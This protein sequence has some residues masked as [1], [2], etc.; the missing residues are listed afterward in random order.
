MAKNAKS[1][2][3]GFVQG[4]ELARVMIV[5]GGATDGG[6]RPL[7]VAE[8]R[9]FARENANSR[10][11]VA[12]A[13]GLRVMLIDGQKRTIAGKDKDGKKAE[14]EPFVDPTLLR[15]YARPRPY[16]KKAPSQQIHLY[17]QTKVIASTLREQEAASDLLVVPV[18]PWPAH[19]TKYAA[20]PPF[21]LVEGHYGVEINLTDGNNKPN[22]LGKFLGFD[23]TTLFGGFGIT[24]S[25]N[26]P[27]ALKA[28]L[29]A[30][31]I[32]FEGSLLD[33]TR[34]EG[35]AE[36][37]DGVFRLE[38]GVTPSGKPSYFL[39]LVRAVTPDQQAAIDALEAR[40]AAAFASLGSAG[41]PVAV[42]Y[43]KRPQV[44]PLIWALDSATDVLKLVKSSGAD[45]EMQ[46]DRGAVDVRIAT[47]GQLGDEEQGLA[48][49]FANRVAWRRQGAAVVEIQVLAGAEASE[50]SLQ[51]SFA[52][53]DDK[54]TLW[55]GQV[56]SFNPNDHLQAPLWPVAER[57][58]PLYRAA[59]AM[60]DKIDHAPYFFIPVEEGCVQIALPAPPY[61]DTPAIVA[62]AAKQPPPSSAMS[63]RIYALGG[64]SVRGLVLDD[65]AGI[66]LTIAWKEALPETVVLKALGPRGQLVGFLFA[67]ESS[68][69]AR[70]ALPNLKGGPA[71]TRDLPLWFGATP[72][73]PYLTTA[74]KWQPAGGKFEATV[75]PNVTPPAEDADPIALAWL[76]SGVSPFVTNHPLT[77]SL[78]AV[79]E[80]SMSRG[81]LPRQLS[82]AFKLSFADDKGHL[83]SFAGGGQTWW[84][85]FDYSPQFRNDTLVL[86]TLA[87][88]EF[89]PEA[90][91]LETFSL[92][93][94]LRFDLPILDELFAWTDPPKKA[95]AAPAT[96]KFEAISLPTAL[97]PIRLKQVWD[98][99]HRRMALTHTQSAH[100]TPWLTEGVTAKKV[101]ISGLVETYSWTTDV[102]VQAAGAPPYGSFKLGTLKF[103]LNGAAEGLGGDKP[104]ALG[105]SGD[106]L[107]E[108]GT[109]VLEVAGFAANLYDLAKMRW[110][111]RGFGVA[112]AAVDGARAAKVRKWETSTKIVETALSL[113]TMPAAASIEGLAD[114][115]AWGFEAPIRFFAR[116]LPLVQA[117]FN[118]MKNPVEKAVGAQGQAFDQADFAESLHEWRLFEGVTSGP[119]ES[120]RRYDIRWGPF[121]FRPLRLLRAEFDKS[122]VKLIQ[123]AGSM[124]LDRPLGDTG[125]PFGPDDI[126]EHGD[127]VQLKLTRKVDAWTYNWAG[128]KMTRTNNSVEFEVD[129]PPEITFEVALTEKGATYRFEKPVMA[130]VT[131]DISKTDSARL[132][133]R[134][135]GSDVVLQTKINAT[136][137]GFTA[138]L[139]AG[140]SKDPADSHVGFSPKLVFDVNGTKSTL[141]ISGPI[142]IWPNSGKSVR[143][144][145]EF[146]PGS[147]DW[148]D[149]TSTASWAIRV[150]HASGLLYGRKEFF[151]PGAVLPV[152]SL[153]AKAG[154]RVTAAIAAVCGRI[155]GPDLGVIQM[156]T[157][158]MRITATEN[159]SPDNRVN[160]RLTVSPAI[161]DHTLELSWSRSFES[162]IRWPIDQMQDEQGHPLDAAWLDPAK[163]NHQPT[164]RSRIVRMA[165]DDNARLRHHVTVHLN[166]HTVSADNLAKDNVTTVSDTV[167]LLA[168]ADHELRHADGSRRAHWTTLDHLA[169]TTPQLM[170]RE[171]DTYTFA[172]RSRDHKYRSQVSPDGQA[173]IIRLTLA[174]AGFHDKL[175]TATLWSKSDR[176]ILL[177]GSAALFPARREENQPRRDY[178]AIV[179]W[180]MMDGVSPIN[181]AAG[182]WRI[183]APDLWPA[184]P[185]EVGGAISGVIVGRKFSSAAILEQFG[186]GR[187]VRSSQDAREAEAIIPVEQAYFE[188]WLPKA[189]NKPAMP[190]KMQPADYHGA[191]FFLRAMMAIESRIKE[192]QLASEKLGGWPKEGFDWRAE[193]LQAARLTKANGFAPA[194]A[195]LRV[196]IGIAERSLPVGPYPSALDES[197]RLLSVTALSPGKMTRRSNYRRVASDV[198]EI[199]RREAIETARDLDQ[200]ALAAIVEI[201][202]EAG[203]PVIDPHPIPSGLDADA[204]PGRMLIKEGTDLTPSAALGWPSDTATVNLHKLSPVLGDELSVLG[205]KS[206]FA[207]RFQAFGWPAFAAKVTPGARREASEASPPEALYLSFSNHIAYDRGTAQYLPD[208]TKVGGGGPLAFDGPTA[209][210]LMPAVTRRRAPG[211]EVT[212]AVLANLTRPGPDSGQQPRATESRAA[213]ILPP[214]VERGTV[215]RRPGVLE[216]AIASITVPGDPKLFD[217]DH[218]RFGRPANSGPLAAHQLRNPRSPVLCA[219]EVPN[220]V[221]AM[222]QQT[223]D[224]RRRTY[225]SLAD[226][227]VKDGKLRLFDAYPG[228]AD[229]VR[230]ETGQRHD[231]AVFTLERETYL[232]PNWNGE[233]K[234]KVE[235][236]A[237]NGNGAGPEVAITGKLQIGDL[238]F[239]LMF[240]IEP[241]PPRQFEEELAFP[242]ASRTIDIEADRLADAR[243]ALM[244]ATADTPIRV[245]LELERRE[246]GG[247]KDL[248][249]GPRGQVIL[250]LALDPGRRRVLPV[251]T[252][253][254]IFADP[255]YDRQ[256]ASQTM[257]AARNISSL[258]KP[259]LVSA[260]RR[261]Y[262][263]GL[264]LYLAGGTVDPKLGT[265]DGDPDAAN[266]E[267]RFFRLP[268]QRDTGE[269]PAAEPLI[270]ASNLRPDGLY[271][272]AAKTVVELPLKQ[273]VLMPTIGKTVPP[274]PAC[275]LRPGDRLQLSVVPIGLF[276]KETFANF[277]I[278]VDIVAEPVIGPPPAVYSVIETTADKS[279]ARVRLHASAPLPQKIEF[280]N[281]LD[282]LALEHVRRRALFV[283]GYPKAGQRQ[284]VNAE[285]DLIK[286]DRSGGAQLPQ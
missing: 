28:V 45:F 117:V 2:I 269:Q 13:F 139:A 204:V 144:L 150:D 249:L 277:S 241:G 3:A 208:G 234:V 143:P 78:P 244:Q 243:E 73:K 218:P 121:A 70:E 252:T 228:A 153:E 57:L 151:F 186:E 44:P 53:L 128:I 99:N 262:D 39:R 226:L 242:V 130:A 31:G 237:L 174:A 62:A 101:K 63:G 239:R 22:Q 89:I 119:G 212:A 110:D 211:S 157:A 199:A 113:Y 97:E 38:C 50:G 1:S 32:E 255:S 263:L 251:E 184:T 167:R 227:E 64:K 168:I 126:Y 60:D 15:A 84:Q 173:G 280:P 67:V 59:R 105:I 194:V 200:A 193:S 125:E 27:K 265:F 253:T 160:H 132:A 107:V 93:A 106:A 8:L 158:W 54:G 47:S 257:S 188:K 90:I 56:T 152:F 224:Y 42:R 163:A 155:T 29:V 12:E 282:D 149:V 69:T 175:L 140:G 196:Q 235:A 225:V 271:E 98:A 216:A 154:L 233:L 112:P 169:I 4:S 185:I 279:V 136:S 147:F 19:E 75:E 276:P 248:P 195:A 281:L 142:S 207:G 179:P 178:A 213:P 87:G 83:P 131:V 165:G 161:R 25:G 190:G 43:D 18:A 94:A 268:P 285:I 278:T 10:E 135:F 88:A 171:V 65:A 21:R 86:T 238:N 273:L 72:P 79:P 215:G 180:L 55:P 80:P 232:G 198:M 177:G 124:R 267:L 189:G 133:L 91:K 223:L 33:P 229:V 187:F 114:K 104:F 77:R 96:A 206:G 20:V 129:E 123:V 74:V 250:P 122:G 100:A 127:L 148:L 275:A 203:A 162:P 6:A 230:F 41:A 103:S 247:R 156:P 222:M 202:E 115:G 81:L 182:L 260:D 108:G 26:K 170:A 270:S 258:E 201:D 240:L 7:Y 11:V 219:D 191:P 48:M 66:D 164:E 49:I 24:V 254:I 266:F 120:I 71:A 192:D 284:Q 36:R 30:Q 176:P 134:L 159:G 146:S 85:T 236:T 214:A 141:A 137:K 166:R 17:A 9:S 256:L 92:Q 52:R 109:D 259:F 76:P 145:A 217:E 220:D 286:F 209:R 82:K 37:I 34:V 116:D 16:P 61:E 23:G 46:I 111:S 246:I 231:K 138:E 102:E 118:G 40:V 274:N 197:V 181:V 272:V 264:T 221:A 172:P 283:W 58:L 5:G 210:H 245:M 95:P 35:G 14:F 205:H 261:E 68:P 51:V 183:A